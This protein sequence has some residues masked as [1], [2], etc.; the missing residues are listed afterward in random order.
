MRRRVASLALAALAVAGAAAPPAAAA[1]GDA[2]NT[3]RVAPTAE[4]KRDLA[5]AGFDLVEGDK[6][7]HL[8]IFATD[9]QVRE[10]RADGIT[11]RLRGAK[12]EAA[13]AA[14]PYT[15]SDAGYTVWT[16]YDAVPGDGKEQFVELYDRL[17]GLG[18]VKKVSIGKTHLGRDIWAVKV[19]KNAKAISDNSRPAVLYNAQQHAREWLAGETCKRTLKYF[20]E[21][22]GQDTEAGA[23]VTP[24]VDTRELWFF[25]VVNPD[26]YEYTFTPGNRLWRKNMADNDGDGVRGEPVDGVDPNRNFPE[27]WGLDNEGS[28]SDPSSETYRGPA[29]DSEPETRAMKKLWDRV[30]FAFQKNDHT[31]A[32]L[33][34]WPQGF[35][36]FTPT[37]DN[38]IFETL[39]GHDHASAIQDD[40]E[41]FDP[42]LSAELYITNGDAL[43]D[44]Y[45]EH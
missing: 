21:N 30:D 27:N 19:T 4:N 40:E 15:G 33:L 24:L 42:D 39:A 9:R 28:S 1:S 29:P 8:E 41:S 5:L 17:A 43:D 36:K 14:A 6:G 32:E 11:A 25:C 10:L 35:Q 34:L 22:Y 20:T 26:G 31:A 12:K 13:A 23:I 37:P 16:R 44:A 7:S 18:H 45:A 38:A 2:L 3:Y